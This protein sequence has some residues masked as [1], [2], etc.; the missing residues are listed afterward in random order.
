MVIESVIIKMLIVKFHLILFKLLPFFLFINIIDLWTIPVI[1]G[2]FHEIQCQLHDSFHFSSYNIGKPFH[3]EKPFHIDKPS[4]FL[5]PE[6]LSLCFAM[7]CSLRLVMVCEE[8]T[9]ICA[10]F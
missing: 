1:S 7:L 2:H 10:N 8:L 9:T 3:I 4:I 5:S 6:K